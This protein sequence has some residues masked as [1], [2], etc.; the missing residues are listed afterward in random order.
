MG[1]PVRIVQFGQVTL[2]QSAYLLPEVVAMITRIRPEIVE[3]V[4]DYLNAI[5]SKST[6]WKI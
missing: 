3:Q 2:V 6:A 5:K 4:I 1:M